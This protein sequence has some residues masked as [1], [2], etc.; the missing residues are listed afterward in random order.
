MANLKRE[1]FNY[2]LL[3]LTERVRHTL[4]HEMCHLAVW[5][6]D[7]GKDGGHGR[8]FKAW[9]VR[10]MKVRKDIEITV[11]LISYFLFT[12]DSP[13][14]IIEYTCIPDNVQIRMEVQ[15]VRSSVCG[16]SLRVYIVAQLCSVGFVIRIQLW[17]AWQIDQSRRPALWRL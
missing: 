7:Q 5:L 1:P 2:L 16:F 11:R 4:S 15:V 9:A 14:R 10:I 8:A 6:I 12:A 3:A 17:P 13:C